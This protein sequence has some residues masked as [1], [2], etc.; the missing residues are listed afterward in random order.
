MAA[1][2]RLVSR[3]T[4]VTGTFVFNSFM[5]FFNLCDQVERWLE[6]FL[7]RSVESDTRVRV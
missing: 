7:Q 6:C 4:L 5:L 3:L 1:A 2:T